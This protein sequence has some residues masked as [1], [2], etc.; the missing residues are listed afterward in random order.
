MKK[1]LLTVLV[2]LVCVAGSFADAGKPLL[3]RPTLGRNQIAFVYAGDLWIVGREGGDARRLTTGIGLETDPIFSPDGSQIAFTGEY[4]GNLDVYVIPA[5]GGQPRRLTYHPGVDV[6]VGWTP[7]GKQVLFR[8]GRSS[9]SRFNRLFT[10]P[11]DGGLPTELPLPMGEEGSFSPDASRIAYVP[12]WNRRSSPGAYISWKHYRGGLASPIW[13]A[14]LADSAIEKVPRKDSN[15]FNPMWVGDKVYF[16][17]DRN[18]PVA[19]F[20]YDTNTKEV[21]P[22]LPNNGLDIHSASA[23]PDAI[24]YD[25]FGA[26]HLFDPKSGKASRVDVRIDAD[27]PWVRTR[28][29]NVGK[30]IRSASLSPT[31]V[32]AVFEARGEILTVPVE[33]GSFRNLTQTPGVAERDPAWSPNGK[34]VAFFSDESGEYQLHLR[35]Q[36]GLGEARKIPLGGG[37]SFYY[38]PRWSPDSKKIAYTDK[39]LNLWYVDV[40]TGKS[41]RIDS[42]TYDSPTR[43]LDPSW[44]PDSRWLTYTKQLRNHLRAVFVYSLET[45]KTRRLT[46]GMSD[47]RFAV[48]DRDGKYL[49]FTAS[50]DIGPTTGWLDMSSFDHPVTR[51]VYVAVLR[52]DLPSPIAPES[53]EEKAQEAPAP[54]RLAAD[55]TPPTTAEKSPKKD[56]KK[57]VEQPKSK[58]KVTVR[59]DFEDID[60]RIL[61]LP[62]PAHNFV[63]MEAA[64]PGVLFL[65]EG[66]R[67]RFGSGA[68]TLHK[69]E[70][71]HRKFE[72]AVD[73]V[74]AFEV[75]H[76]A[77]KMLV[78]MGGRWF[79]TSTAM[80]RPGDGAI[81]TEELEVQVDPRAEWK[82]MYREVWRI[83][84]DFLYDPGA[85]GVDLKAAERQYA[86]YLDGVG[87]R[88]DLNYL[89]DE[90]LGQITIGHLYIAGG[91]VPEI[92]RVRGGLLGADYQVD[93]GRYRF[94]RVYHGENWNPGMRAPL[95]Q[96]GVNVKAGEYLLAVN[97]KK[98]TAADNLYRVFEATAGRA[99]SLKV[100]PKPDETG[101]REVTV[102]PIESETALR[103][104][105]WIADNRRKVDRLSGG[106]L[107]YVYLP[108]TSLGGYTN[109]NRYYFAQVDK[110]GAVLDERFNGGGT[111]ADYI[112]DYM[113]R[114]LMNY[115]TTR[116]G[117]DFPTPVGSIFGPKAMI[118]NEFAGSGGDAMPWYFR[119]AGIGPLVGKRTWGGLVGIYDYPPLLDGG[120]VTAPRL[121]FWNP[122]KGSWEVENHGVPPDMEVDLDPAAVRQGH[123]PQ[124]EKAV[125]VV[126]AE[127]KKQP[128]PKHHHPAFP[129]YHRPR[130]GAVGRR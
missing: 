95:T 64:K 118:I 36:R 94:A 117:A 29:E 14:H 119:K 104:L 75:S 99:V 129:N 79:I 69:F 89:F 41:T 11:L 123:D 73:S 103:N 92:K 100:G 46:D 59:I 74:S 33:K 107:A 51:S 120:F 71:S 57:P 108:D 54:A 67:G 3:Q 81:R 87:S 124:L 63:A 38:S 48:F 53:D 121:A 52:K 5:T 62:I 84:R 130:D 97:G 105:A 116:E 109:F 6:A 82:Q 78:G 50:T 7:D 25:Q 20:T 55:D 68:G 88:A 76:N 26:L 101:A 16:L 126:L 125:Q 96:P 8:S 4:E 115:W 61:A 47:A 98:L 93:N 49:Y 23:G 85:H 65:L 18:G 12:F 34:W 66:G 19:L 40:A 32:R 13:I 30:S 37:P 112:I 90:M 10:I 45:G 28:Y 70:L 1:L 72:K 44:S 102:V 127:L 17:S 80:P 43:S 35:D 31:G 77:E 83:E 21:Q 122:D 58:D 60:Q 22:V 86:A 56:P 110:E 111:A 91:D 42:D 113:R 114:P 39:R 128:P 27:L 9:Y 24:V 2:F 15:D 106:K